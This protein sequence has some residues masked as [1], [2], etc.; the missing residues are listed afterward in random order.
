MSF[1]C[2]NLIFS[3]GR[4][5][6]LM[7]NPPLFGS[8]CNSFMNGAVVGLFDNI[9][10]SLRRFS[11]TPP[12]IF[13]SSC[14]GSIPI[15]DLNIDTFNG[16]MQTFRY[17][18]PINTSPGYLSSFNTNSMPQNIRSLNFN[19]VGMSS[20]TF[21]NTYTSSI[22]SNTAGRYANLSAEEIGAQLYQQCK[23]IARRRGLTL[24]FFVRVA[25]MAKKINCDPL[26][27]LAKMYASS[28]LKPYAINKE[29]GAV[30]LNQLLPK[31]RFITMAGG[32]DRYKNMSAIEQLDYIEAY[33]LDKAKVFNGRYLEGEDIFAMNFLPDYATRDVLVRRGE[34]Y[35][36]P[37]RDK[38]GDGDIDKKD[39]REAYLKKLNEML[40]CR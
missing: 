27:L 17:D 18:I 35:Y 37:L 32:Y 22:N 26:A 38:D 24:Q 29:T 34:R 3:M 28:G 9:M 4:P 19:F 2:N 13:G 23:N 40:N 7:G 33:W 25:Q 15:P 10:S 31:S 20:P 8:L 36:D 39:M 6:P 21:T 11:Y 5:M 12:T 16:R 14:Y 1:C 30:G